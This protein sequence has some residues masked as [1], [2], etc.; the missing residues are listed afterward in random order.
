M[1]AKRFR[2]TPPIDVINVIS[3]YIFFDDLTAV[4]FF[5]TLK[6]DVR[7]D[8]RILFIGE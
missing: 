8:G 6:K 4:F 5:V 1:L 3:I 7:D 2:E